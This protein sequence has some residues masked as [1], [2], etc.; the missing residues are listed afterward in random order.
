MT[1]PFRIESP[2]TTSR[3]VTAAPEAGATGAAGDDIKQWMDRLI[4]LVPAEVVAVYLAGRGYATNWLGIWATVCLVLVFIVRIWGTNEPVKGVQWPAVGVAAVSFVIWVY[5][6]GGNF[7]NLTLP[8]PGIA[9][10]AVLVW[11][12]VVPI[13][14]KGD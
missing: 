2:E 11:T 8:D 9:S 1:A 14:Y 6:M 5:A 7:L 12:V 10:A 3:G 4:R 13:F